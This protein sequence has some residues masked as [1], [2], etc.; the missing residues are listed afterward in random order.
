MK[1]IQYIAPAIEVS[2][3]VLES[4]LMDNSVVSVTGLDDV[5]KGEGDFAGG[6][7]DVKRQDY[8]V[9]NDDWSK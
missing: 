4:H 6:S 3:F 9:W 7:A 8:N 1:K 5:T 2:T